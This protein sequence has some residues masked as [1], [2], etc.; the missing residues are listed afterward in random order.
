MKFKQASAGSFNEGSLMML[1]Q[2]NELLLE[3]Q[4]DE[5]SNGER[6][7]GRAEREREFLRF[8]NAPN[9]SSS[10]RWSGGGSIYVQQY[11]RKKLRFKGAF[12]TSFAF[13]AGISCKGSFWVLPV[14]IL[15]P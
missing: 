15:A 3:T 13:S 1:L 6:A 8:L 7:Q 14:L 9:D 10:E 12:P 2:Y 5:K 4:H 11:W